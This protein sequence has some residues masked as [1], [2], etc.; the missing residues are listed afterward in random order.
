MPEMASSQTGGAERRSNS[1]WGRTRFGVLVPLGIVVAVAIACIIVAALMSAH[2]ADV[3]ALERERQLLARAITTHGEWSLGR[4]RTVI[5]SSASVSAGD[6]EQSPA[7]VQQRLGAWLGP[8]SD[9][10]L[11]LVLNSGNEIAYSQQ[12]HDTPDLTLNKAAFAQLQ[13]IAEFTRGRLHT[14]P[15]HV[16]HLLSA[17]DGS[18]LL[19]NFDGRLALS[20]AIPVHDPGG[21][22]NDPAAGPIVLTLRLVGPKGLAGMGERIQL[23]DLTMVPSGE[24]PP[25]SNSLDFVDERGE[26]VAHFSWLPRK[27]GAEI[28]QSVI[29]F[30]GI[31]LAGFALLSWLV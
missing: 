16:M 9:H 8:L 27:P 19:H 7:Q 13:S 17:A 18:V 22:K 3:V 31:A 15:P 24:I 21:A 29:P 12:G 11:V 20:T 10:N 4:L 25:G 28:L 26:P 30:I 14:L 23:T 2:R 1:G 5:A 6:I